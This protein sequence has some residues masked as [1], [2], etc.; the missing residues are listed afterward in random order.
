M[1]KRVK[2][3]PAAFCWQRQIFIGCQQS[4]AECGIAS[5]YAGGGRW[6]MANTTTTWEYQQRIRAL[7]FGTRCGRSQSADWLISHGAHQPSGSLRWG[8][9]HRPVDT[10]RTRSAW[11][12]S[13]R[14]ASKSRV[15]AA[16]KRVSGTMRFMSLC[17]RRTRPRGIM[18]LAR[19][20]I[21]PQHGQGA[22][23]P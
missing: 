16:G 17:R 14:S 21:L 4:F 6:R 9:D 7:P 11:M 1:M 15:T 22:L 12:G 23:C 3:I 5:I 20:I 8:T 13:R 19:R 10:P 2:C 18:R